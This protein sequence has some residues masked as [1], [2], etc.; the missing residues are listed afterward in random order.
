MR[1]P[2]PKQRA[3]YDFLLQYKETHDGNAPSREVIAAHFKCSHQNIDN[4]LL[5]LYGKGLIDF[6]EQRQI[7]IFGGQWIAPIRS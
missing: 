1:L 2:W 3:I 7:V 5:R 6:D 4:Q